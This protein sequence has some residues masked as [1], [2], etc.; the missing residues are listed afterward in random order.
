MCIRDRC[1]S[2]HHPAVA[3]YQALSENN[4]VGN[5]HQQRLKQLTAELE[6]LELQGKSLSAEQERLKDKLNIINEN[7]STKLQEQQQLTTQWL[8]LREQ[9]K[10]ELELSA[11]EQINADMQAR[12]QHFEALNNANNQL[13]KL[14]Q[15]TQQQTELVLGLDK[16]LVNLTNLSQNKTVQLNQLHQ[17]AEQNKQNLQSQLAKIASTY[18]KLSKLMQD[19]QTILPDI[20]NVYQNDE[21]AGSEVAT[22]EFSDVLPLQNAWLSELEQQGQAYQTALNGVATENEQLQQIQQQLAIAHSK[23]E[24][25][26]LTEQAIKDEL[27]LIEKQQDET[28]LQ[29]KTLFGEQDT[30]QARK[31][32]KQQQQT[33]EQLLV[34]LQNNLSDQKSLQQNIAGKLNANLAAISRLLPQQQVAIETWQNQLAQSDFA[35][36]ADFKAALLTQEQRLNLKSL[37]QEI[38]QKT[39][40]AKAQLTQVQQQLSQLEQDKVKLQIQTKAL[41]ESTHVDADN[42]TGNNAGNINNDERLNDLMFTQSLVL[43]KDLDVTEFDHKAAICAETLKQLQIRQGQLSQ[44]ISQDIQQRDEQ[45]SLL[46]EITKQQIALDDLSHLNGL[47]GAADGA[48]F[49]RFAQGLTLSHLVYLANQQ[50]NKLHGRYQLQCQQSENLALEVLDTWQA[51]S[52]RDTKTLSG[53]ESFLVSLALALALSDLV[54]AKTSIDSLFLDEGFGTLDNDTLEIALSALDSLNASGKMIGVISHVDA[55]KKRIDVQI[56]VKK[57]NGLGVSELAE[58]YRYHGN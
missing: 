43:E 23:I 3:D 51:D 28:R 27:M 6:Q 30:Q 57:Q 1:G 25:L 22:N 33:Q 32:L 34:Q 4:S 31:Q 19:N 46:D 15:T 39:Q 50:L 36:E 24:Q 14:K 58:C 10:I 12:K 17:Q 53:G 9:L 38:T 20:F 13:Q 35:T 54:S 49:R 47:I 8:T 45:K 44:Q 29:R 56:E 42:D 41:V 40:Q 16:Q 48:R 52:V 55:L 21:A 18:Q 11:F 26:S 7:K 37:Q 5:E 2:D